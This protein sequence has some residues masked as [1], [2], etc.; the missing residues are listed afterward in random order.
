MS[1]MCE[2]WKEQGGKQ[3]KPGI[4]ELESATGLAICKSGAVTEAL[5]RPENQGFKLSS[6]PVGLVKDHQ[7]VGLYDK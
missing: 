7:K 5:I 3:K 2:G 4:T 6:F 1:L